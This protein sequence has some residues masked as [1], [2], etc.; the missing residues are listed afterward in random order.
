MTIN[1]AGKQALTKAQLDDEAYRAQFG[2]S[3]AETERLRTSA[4]DEQAAAD[5]ARR[6]AAHKAKHDAPRLKAVDRLGN[7]VVLV[8]E[9]S[10]QHYKVSAL[11]ILALP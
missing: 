10:G 7:D 11:E 6:E 9:A 5:I 2:I 1:D 3:R 4:T 8:D